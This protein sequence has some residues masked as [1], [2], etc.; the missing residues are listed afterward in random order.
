M[1]DNDTFINHLE[2]LRW[3]LLRMLTATAL[4]YPVGYILSPWI[5]S[6]L[7]QWCCPHTFGVLHYFAPMEVFLVRLKLALIVALILGCPW[8]MMQICRFLLPALYHH[9][10]QALVWW[11]AGSSFLFLG[12]IAFYVC[13]I[14]PLL[15]KFSAEFATNDIQPILGLSSF[16]DLAGWLSLAFGLM[17]QV[18]VAVLLAVKFGVISTA[19]LERKRPYV[20]TVILVFAAI[21]TPPD[22]VS[23]VMLALPTWILFELGL[24]LSS[25]I[26]RA[27]TD[28]HV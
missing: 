26:E 10:R 5:I 22:V 25:K 11:L 18:P 6:A 4:L 1:P 27:D 21:L 20:M 24:L 28:D 14:L 13:C 16:L 17:F 19:S 2:E 7:V 12:G 15:M 9:E 3:T 23:Q 8:N